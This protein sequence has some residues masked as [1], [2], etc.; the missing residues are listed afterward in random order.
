MCRVSIVGVLAR[1]ARSDVNHMLPGTDTIASRGRI[2]RL[3]VAKFES[4][5]RDPTL[6]EAVNKR[7]LST[8]EPGEFASGN[9]RFGLNPGFERAP[10]NSLLSNRRNRAARKNLRNVADTGEPG[11]RCCQQNKGL[12]FGGKVL[13]PHRMYEPCA[14]WGTTLCRS[15]RWGFRAPTTTWCA[16]QP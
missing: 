16:P 14:T 9:L 10:P 11:G 5:S 15:W 13:A 1:R 6:Y 3:A 12:E 8:G 7:L 4:R 2:D